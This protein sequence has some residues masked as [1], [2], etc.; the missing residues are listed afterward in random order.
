[1]NKLIQFVKESY[2]ELRKVIWPGRDD[3]VS[4]VKVVVISTIIIAAVLG[5]V[6][7]LLLFGIRA[8]F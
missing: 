3:V 1:M 2:A 7:V 6:D 5:L 4:S 8:I